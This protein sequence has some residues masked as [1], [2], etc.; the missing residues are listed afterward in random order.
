MLC[1][2]C[3]TVKTSHTAYKHARLEDK[4][5]KFQ[6]YTYWSRA[7]NSHKRAHS[8]KHR[9]F[10]HGEMQT[11]SVGHLQSAVPTEIVARCTRR[12]NTVM[13]FLPARSPH[14][15]SRQGEQREVWQTGEVS[16]SYYSLAHTST[17]PFCGNAV[18][19]ANP[20]APPP[21]LLGSSHTSADAK[22]DTAAQSALSHRNTNGDTHNEAQW[23]VAAISTIYFIRHI[24]K[25]WD[26]TPHLHIKQPHW[27]PL[28]SHSQ[29]HFGVPHW[30]KSLKWDYVNFGNK[31]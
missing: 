25:R 31:K 6:L 13:F 7:V 26:D 23:V 10:L 9:V 16:V 22:R 24:W 29:L 2:L 1:L 27:W 19:S 3:R 17:F 18:I 11:E 30:L 21:G 8:H 5:N 14:T 4:P 12:A 28:G 20:S 15:P